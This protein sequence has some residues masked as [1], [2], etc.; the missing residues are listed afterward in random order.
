M[1][2]FTYN[3]EFFSNLLYNK[4]RKAGIIME[5]NTPR[6]Q[7]PR[8]RRKTKW[9]IIKEAYLP[10]VILIITLI[11][12]VIFVAGS[13]ARRSDTKET[14]PPET[15]TVVPTEDPY[16]GEAAQLLTEAALLA[17]DYDYKAAADL[18]DTFRGDISR[19][20][21]LSAMRDEYLAAEANMITWSDLSQIKTLSFHTL[22]ADPARAFTNA[23]YG[24]SYNKNFITIAE[25]KEILRQLYDNNYILVSLD[26]ICYAPQT[27]GEPTDAVCSIKQLRLPLGKKPLLLVQTNANYYTYM[28]DGNGDGSPDKDG[29]GLQAVCWLVPTAGSPAKWSIAMATPSKAH[30][31]WSLF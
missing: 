16:K 19:Y 1:G 29:A 23:A 3:L 10:T 13:L 9:E 2:V 5:E 7:N 4:I 15:T 20:P 30:L 6:P 14:T 12:I 26:D 11:L 28:V 21:Q 18:I 17:A 8:R 24:A 27:S 31:I 22:I 25:F